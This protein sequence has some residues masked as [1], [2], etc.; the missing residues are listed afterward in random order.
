MTEVGGGLVLSGTVCGSGLGKE[1]SGI[2]EPEMGVIGRS[3]KP[4]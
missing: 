2:T 4:E 3:E 1:K